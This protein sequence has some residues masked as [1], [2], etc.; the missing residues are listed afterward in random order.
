MRLFIALDLPTEVSAALG[1]VVERLRPLANLRWS[2]VENLHITTKFIG[3]LPEEK[4]DEAREAL[5]GLA[6]RGPLLVRVGGLGWY[7]NARNPRVLWA[8]V[9][10]GEALT[11]LARETDEALERIGVPGETRPY[12][13]HLTLA[14][15]GRATTNGAL[16]EEVE[17]CGGAV[18]GELEVARFWLYESRRAPGGSVYTKLSA[19]PFRGAA[20]RL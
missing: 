6:S 16:R 9:W 20:E 14:R 17:R 5:N 4:L 11:N 18:F 7:P 12:A 10:G 19:F 13:P 3:E 15:V 2:P 8:G 1:E